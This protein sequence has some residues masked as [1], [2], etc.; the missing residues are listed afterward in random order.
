MLALIMSLLPLAENLTPLLI[1][2]IQQI[3]AQPGMTDE[4]IL[5]HAKTTSDENTVT[6]LAERLRLINEISAGGTQ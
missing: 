1:Q 3:K 5:A 2:L 6:L 4:V